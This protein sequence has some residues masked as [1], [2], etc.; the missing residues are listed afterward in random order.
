MR[1]KWDEL[2]EDQIEE[3]AAILIGHI[4]PDSHRIDGSGG[5]GG[6]GFD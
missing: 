6:R 1:I 2:S 5:D 3:L 4:N